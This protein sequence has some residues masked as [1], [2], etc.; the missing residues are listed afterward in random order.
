MK[1]KLTTPYSMDNEEVALQFEL[2]PPPIFKSVDKAVDWALTNLPYG[3]YIELHD[4]RGTLRANGNV[5]GKID[6][7]QVKSPFVCSGYGWCEI[8]GEHGP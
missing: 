1:L 8:H 5:A 2:A 4:G 6:T 7:Y 3:V